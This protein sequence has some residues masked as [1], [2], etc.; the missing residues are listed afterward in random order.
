M[1]GCDCVWHIEDTQET[2]VEKPGALW[3]E[4]FMSSGPG[5]LC[6]VGMVTDCMGLYGESE[7]CICSAGCSA[8]CKL[9]VSVISHNY[10]VLIQREIEGHR[11]AG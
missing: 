7:Y 9:P 6:I 10:S 11:W 1:T 3:R 8:H 4:T 5:V 2:V